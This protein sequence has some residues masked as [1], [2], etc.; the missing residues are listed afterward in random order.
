MELCHALG[1]VLPGEVV[2][3]VGAGGKTS[4]MYRLARELADAGYRGVVTTTTKVWVPTPEQVPELV[5]AERWPQA[6][7]DLEAALARKPLVALGASRGPEGKLYGIDP[8]WVGAL[9][10]GLGVDFVLV[11]A[12]GAAGRPLKGPAGHEPVIPPSTTLLV[13]VV[14][15]SAL[16]QPLGSET[17][18]RPEIVA[19]LTGLSLGEAITPQ[20]VARL[21]LHPE[22]NTK[23]APASARVVPLINQVD[24]PQA[25]ALA[26]DVAALVLQQGLGRVVLSR[27][28]VEP[29]E[30]EVVA[31][32]VGNAGERPWSRQ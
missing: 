9:R 20:A 17:A 6:V 19:R 12:D 25:R 32:L 8:D 23:G 27:L 5:V 16:G 2:S 11:E 29:P 24:T 15:A 31:A 3:L 10:P 7:A 26:Q 13:P 1:M 18:H 28:A 21:L 4:A 14:G 30:F 22:G